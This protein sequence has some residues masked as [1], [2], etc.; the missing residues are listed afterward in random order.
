MTVNT[1]KCV[2]V[3]FGASKGA[4]RGWEWWFAGEPL[5]QADSFKYLGTV[6]TRRS[7]VRGALDAV[8]AAGVRAR[9]A[10]VAAAR[11]AG[12]MDLHQRRQ[13]FSALVLPVVSYG[14]EIWGPL[15]LAPR[16]RAGSQRG[17]AHTLQHNPLQAV[18]SD[19]LRDLV[20]VRKGVPAP[21]LLS[22]AGTDALGVHWLKRA[23]G[24]WER[25]RQRPESD[26]ARLAVVDGVAMTLAGRRSGRSWYEA[27]LSCVQQCVPGLRLA[28]EGEA[29]AVELLPAPVEAIVQ[30][31]RALL[32]P[33]AGLD[34]VADPRSP[35]TERRPWA[36]YLAWFRAGAWNGSRMRGVLRAL[37]PPG[38]VAQSE[39]APAYGGVF[40]AP[41]RAYMQLRCGGFGLEVD[42]GRTRTPTVPYPL[43]LCTRCDSGTVEDALHVVWECPAY[44]EVR[45]RHPELFASFSG[46]LEQAARLRG[47]ACRAVSAR[48]RAFFQQDHRRLAWLAYDLQRFRA[49]VVVQSLVCHDGHL[50]TL[51]SDGVDLELFEDTPCLMDLD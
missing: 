27:F 37:R 21:I 20:G 8:A 50:D 32:I 5:P 36:T 28:R 51:S 29:G 4:K 11:R 18:Q 16:G 47:G 45:A 22:E 41:A 13:L 48:F 14:C 39:G 46:D 33:L 49:Q 15:I 25:I 40:G 10:T 44:S 12:V 19:F 38:Q 23:A 24:M 43:R 31:A 17:L 7:G 30:G 9:A 35:A 1:A 3:T 42:R 26:V 2:V 6:F 34:G